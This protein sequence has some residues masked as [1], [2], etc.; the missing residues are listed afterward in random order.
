M[1][2]WLCFSIGCSASQATYTHTTQRVTRHLFYF[3]TTWAD[4]VSSHYFP[5]FVRFFHFVK[6][7]G[8]SGDR[9]SSI[10]IFLANVQLWEGLWSHWLEGWLLLCSTH[11][12]VQ[13]SIQCACKSPV[14][15]ESDPWQALAL[16]LCAALAL[17]RSVSWHLLL[18]RIAE[19]SSSTQ[20][21]SPFSLVRMPYSRF[22]SRDLKAIPRRN[23][24]SATT[25]Y[26]VGI[27]QE[28]SKLHAPNQW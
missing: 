3:K 2:S 12:C 1:I 26:F 13:S 22:D 15:L 27:E 20:Q 8:Q 10:M 23:L 5:H 18:V 28:Q 4:T 9:F 6:S 24:A 11:C 17:L 7:I 25:I 14:R 21:H 19:A 16:A